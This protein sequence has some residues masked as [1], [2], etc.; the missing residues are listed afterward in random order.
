MA[1]YRL[2][3]K[4]FGDSEFDH[5]KK[6]KGVFG[7]GVSGGQLAL[8]GT[9][10]LVGKKQYQNHLVRTGQAN[11]NVMARYKNGSQKQKNLFNQGQ[12]TITSAQNIEA[13]QQLSSARNQANITK[14]IDNIKHEIGMNRAANAQAAAT[15]AGSTK[16]DT[17][18]M[19]QDAY[20]SYSLE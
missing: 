20:N 4:I 5:E 1:T 17:R 16:K 12:K 8:I 10:A 6:D 14:G 18:T 2:K 15:L 7:L 3:S 13:N 11:A 19:V 9:A